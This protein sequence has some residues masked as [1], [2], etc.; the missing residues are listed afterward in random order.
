[1]TA[2]TTAIPD[3]TTDK[4]P[5]ARRR[6]PLSLR[7]FVVVLLILGL[8]CARDGL[9]GYRQYAAVREVQRLGGAISLTQNGPAFL[10]GWAPDLCCALFD[11]VVAVNLVDRPATD[12]TMA[13]LRGLDSLRHLHIDNTLVSDAGLAHLTG[14]IRLHELSV[15]RTQVSDAGLRH[16]RGLN[17]LRVL[18]LMYTR[19]TDESIAELKAALPE[20][21]V[22]K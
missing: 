11:E 8:V 2:P 12:D 14:L 7:M 19:V 18:G 13:Y 20:L 17:R 15:C 22:F 5:R 21:I 4:P 10:R 3:L 9:R 6:L 1:M 16:F